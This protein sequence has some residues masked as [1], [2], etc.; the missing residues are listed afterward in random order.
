MNALKVDHLRIETATVGDTI[1]VRWAGELAARNPSDKVVTYL[2]LLR[3]TLQRKKVCIDFC[4]FEYMNSASVTLV[5][6]FLRASTESSQSMLIRYRPALQW[7]KTFFGAMRVIAR[8]WN[9]SVEIQGV[10]G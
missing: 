9:N 7:Q 5:M 3:A 4:E 2:D 10:E 1:E 8:S 6:D